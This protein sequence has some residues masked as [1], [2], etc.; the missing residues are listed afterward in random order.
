MDEFGDPPDNIG[1]K[2]HDELATYLLAREKYAV[3]VSRKN[4]MDLIV[5]RKDRSEVFFPTKP[6]VEL[7]VAL[8]STEW[9][10]GKSGSQSKEIKLESEIKVESGS[11]K[12]CSYES[13][14]SL[15]SYWVRKMERKS[16][17]SKYAK[18]HSILGEYCTSTTDLVSR[19]CACNGLTH[20]NP[21]SLLLLISIFDTGR[22]DAS[23]G[24]RTAITHSGRSREK[25]EYSDFKRH[26]GDDGLH[27]S[28]TARI[29]QRRPIQ[30]S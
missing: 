10:Y 29:Y 4:V 6:Y 21:A 1:V 9:P 23:S 5:A 27:R 26:C 24:G 3:H 7:S 17:S 11:D 22:N 15:G 28:N 2:E 18:A 20:K 16:N 8:S 19:Y 30:I 25:V 14:M 12:V 13:V